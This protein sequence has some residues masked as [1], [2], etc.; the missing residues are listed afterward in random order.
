MTRIY[1]HLKG[2][3]IFGPRLDWIELILPIIQSTA[4]NATRHSNAIPI[5][6]IMTPRFLHN[7]KLRSM[8]SGTE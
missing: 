8:C 4:N 1:G 7:H 5:I 2:Q 3:I 6:L